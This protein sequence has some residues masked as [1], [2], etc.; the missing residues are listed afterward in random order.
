MERVHIEL[1]A[2]FAFATEMDVRIADINYGRHVGNDTLLSYL[3]E[4]R[5]RFLAQAGFSEL[6]V[7][8]CGL[9]MT[10]AALH[11]LG[12]AFHGDRLRI[13]V[14]AV[15][16]ARASFALVYRVQRSSDGREIL[17]ARTGMA[18]FDYARNRPVRMPE[19]FRR[20]FFG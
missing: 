11:Y 19:A 17:R 13:E 6:D 9:I 1:P 4:A 18:F 5:L 3:H 14:S 7:G 8:G 10:D 15:D 2:Q 20:A 12:Q 16:P